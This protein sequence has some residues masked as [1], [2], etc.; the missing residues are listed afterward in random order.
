M[1]VSEPGIRGLC[2]TTDHSRCGKP[3]H[4]SSP[5]NRIWCYRMHRRTSS[6]LCVY[7]YF[8][9]PRDHHHQ[10]ALRLP[11]PIP[12]GRSS[13]RRSHPP[14]SW[15][16]PPCRCPR[17]QLSALPAL[18]H[19]SVS[20][21][22]RH[23]RQSVL[24]LFPVSLWASVKRC[25]PDPSRVLQK[26]FWHSILTCPHP[27]ISV[28]HRRPLGNSLFRFYRKTSILSRNVFPANYY[29]LEFLSLKQVIDSGSAD[30]KHFLQFFDLITSLLHYKTPPYFVPVVLPFP[31]D[32]RQLLLR[33]HVIINVFLP[34]PLIGEEYK[35]S[36]HH[37]VT[38]VV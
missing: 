18:L 1:N 37:T 9:I 32:M 5:Y 28:Y 10:R 2:Q 8:C 19:S 7:R 6:F 16:Q 35:I 31:R 33:L 29:P 21:P 14:L 22:P 25:C 30:T 26:T 27:L 15:R 3:L 34:Y 24:P 20:S 4:T 23:R 36:H 13:A 17:R 11:G 38:I 12:P